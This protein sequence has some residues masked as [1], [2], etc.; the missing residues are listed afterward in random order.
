M[1]VAKV[2]NVTGLFDRLDFDGAGAVNRE[3]ACQLALNTLKAT[4]VTYGGTTMVSG[5]QTL[6]VQ[7]TQAMY[8]TSNNREINANINRRVINAVNNEM[9]LEFGEEHFKDLRLEHDKYDPAY[10]IYGHP[11]NEWSYKKVTIGTFKLPADFT[12]TKQISHLEDSVATK[13]KALGLRNYDTYS[14]DHRNFTAN[15]STA[16]SRSDWNSPFADATQITIN[17]WNARVRNT[18][19]YETQTPVPAGEKAGNGQLYSY[20]ANVIG[21]GTRNQA[22]TLAEIADLTDNGVTVEVYVCPVDADFITNVVVTRTQLMK[23]KTVGSDYVRLEDIEPDSRDPYDVPSLGAITGYNAFAIDG[24]EWSGKAIADVK[25]DNYDAYNALKDMKAGDYVAV[26]PYTAD[27]GKTWEVGEAYAPETVS[28]RMT[29]VDIYNSE[30]KRD[31]NAI[32]ITV[33][34]TSYP[35]NEWNLDMLDITDNIIKS[36]RK[37]VTVY[38]A[39]D[40]TALWTTEVGNTDAWM[41]VADYYQGTNDSGKVVWYVHGYT[42]GGD[43]V[44]LDLGTIRGAAEKYAP[45]ELVRYR[46]NTASGTGEYVLEKP[47]SN[48]ASVKKGGMYAPYNRNGGVPAYPNPSIST[49]AGIVEPARDKYEG[50][51]RV[52]LA[53]GNTPTDYEVKKNLDYIALD[54]YPAANTHELSTAEATGLTAG[55]QWD[56]S[57]LY[58]ASNPTFIFVDFDKSGEIETINFIKGRQ[59]IRHEDL[60]EYN[61]NWRNVGTNNDDFVASTAEAYVNDKGLVETVVIKTDSA[62]AN[63]SGLRIITKNTGSNNYVPKGAEETTSLTGKWNEREYVQGPDFN[64]AKT[65]VFDKGYQVGDI[66]VGNEKDGIFYAKAFHGDE[67]RGSS[68]DGF[69]VTGIQKVPNKTQLDK[70]LDDCF[71]IVEGYSKYTTLGGAT[72]TNAN[73][74]AEFKDLLKYTDEDPLQPVKEEGLIRCVGAKIIDVRVGH[75]GE[76]TKLKDLLDTDKFDLSKMTLK[77]LLNGKHGDAG[78]R[79]AYAV[80]IIDAP[81]AGTGSDTTTGSV[82]LSTAGS[83]RPVDN[84]YGNVTV[85]KYTNG[86]TVDL[87]FTTPAWGTKNVL[88]TDLVDFDVDLK[89]NGETFAT[90]KKSNFSAVGVSGTTFTTSGTYTIPSSTVTSGLIDPAKD[91]FTA[92]LKNVSWKYA[93]VVY[94]YEGGASAADEVTG[95]DKMAI[96]TKAGF[97][98]MFTKTADQAIIATGLS[99]TVAGAKFDAPQPPMT[100]NTNLTLANAY[101][102]GGKVVTITIKGVTAAAP[103]DKYDVKSLTTGAKAIEFLVVDAV[104]AA[105][106]IPGEGWLTATQAAAGKI[107]LVRSSVTGTKL[108]GIADAKNPGTFADVTVAESATE[109]PTG[110][111]VFQFTMPANA[112]TVT[113]VNTDAVS[114]TGAY[115]SKT[116][117]INALTSGAKNFKTGEAIAAYIT[118]NVSGVTAKAVADFDDPTALEKIVLTN[119]AGSTK[120]IGASDITVGANLAQVTVGTTSVIAADTAANASVGD[121]LTL[122]GITVDGAG[123]NVYVVTNKGATDGLVACATDT[124]GLATKLTGIESI[125]TNSGKGYAKLAANPVTISQVAPLDTAAATGVF[126]TASVTAMK[127]GDK[128]VKVGEVLTITVTA[129]NTVTD[130]NNTAGVTFEDGPTTTATVSDVTC[131]GFA[132]GTAIAATDTVDVTLKIAAPSAAAV[133]ILLKPVAIP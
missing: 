84:K 127:N 86:V 121:V 33:G 45:G 26:V 93:D 73:G 101:A 27:E 90:L 4:M 40:G 17:G 48:Q 103:A 12:Y 89:V 129:N 34:G 91:V 18:E 66:L 96:G 118:A 14:T 54:R 65:G 67:Y 113:D 22:P 131:A 35:I 15:W 128:L 13:E 44:N 92:V 3:T 24:T 62:E 117:K 85:N 8:V 99:Y 81:K 28:G 52:A 41:V 132:A 43:E 7:G 47:N 88:A 97:T 114:V 36:T 116:D 110:T 11:S 78:F 23:V 126:A 30:K 104:P 29:R 109:I 115:I 106:A 74:L 37:D 122:E 125:D 61:K 124:A 1:N 105:D 16:S 72:L 133:T 38:L 102:E 68:L 6:A 20:D 100:D 95:P 87:K 53:Y 10:D 32:A 108:T 21:S 9:T 77:V 39:K 80:V 69:T 25:D 119:S 76:I 5:A 46:I 123:A 130:A 60:S 94:Q 79:N 42:L 2:G 75:E 58:Y 112:V 49:N 111:G 55:Y 70:Y 31:G 59:D 83:V 71:K 98:F 50:I 19:L 64:E 107:V 82:S 57:T 120:D 56:V 63:L 51:Y